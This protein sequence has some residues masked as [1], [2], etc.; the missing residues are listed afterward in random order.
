MVG[1]YGGA[2]LEYGAITEQGSDAVPATLGEG[3]AASAG[4]A[5]SDN[6]ALRLGRQIRRTAAESDVFAADP[7][8]GYPIQPEQPLDPE[9]ANAEFGIKGV[10]SFDKP[11][12][13]A[14]AQDLY[15]HKREQIERDDVIAR[16][17]GG[18]GAGAARLTAYVATSL[19]DPI[20]V[21]AGFIPVIGPAR[22]AALVAR[23]GSAVARARVRAGIGGAAGAAG[24]T[25]LQPLEFALSRQER[26]DYTMADALRSIA[27]GT[28]LGGGLHAGAGAAIDRAAGR[29]DPL[30]GW[31]IN[32]AT[33][34]P[35]RFFN[36]LAQRIEDAGPEARETLLHGALA[37]SIEGRPVNVAPVLD[38]VEATRA[39][40]A[41]RLRAATEDLRRSDIE[42][43]PAQREDVAARP[44]NDTLESLRAEI[45]DLERLEQSTAAPEAPG[46]GTIRT[47][48][49][50]DAPVNVVEIGEARASAV[51]HA[52]ICLSRSG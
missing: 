17:E 37:Q 19:L 20:N 11:V 27:L 24:M 48:V 2:P 49:E 10:L 5:I 46:A 39:G 25:A 51:E 43:L 50:V 4:E 32:P 38:A 12:A 26:E 40:D 8:M 16:S 9:A 6:L 13:R 44:D 14:V 28:V 18:I 29:F 45:A 52:A 22:E 1:F 33:G 15:E 41:P 31:P 42:P 34:E 7:M 30:T 21:A 35:E 3:I 47:G 36:P 23:A